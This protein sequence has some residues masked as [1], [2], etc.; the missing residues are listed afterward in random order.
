MC[1]NGI[2]LPSPPQPNSL[3][4]RPVLLLDHH[5]AQPVLLGF[6]RLR[7]L[8][9]RR[10]LPRL[11]RHLALRLLKWRFT[12]G[13]FSQIY[14]DRIEVQNLSDFNFYPTWT[15]GRCH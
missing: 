5:R 3:V 8:L 11:H 2:G 14:S 15:C 10:S 6:Q 1:R 9:R 13:I 7:V 4:Q 12:N